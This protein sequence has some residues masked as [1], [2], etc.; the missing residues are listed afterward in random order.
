[1]HGQCGKLWTWT[2]DILY[3]VIVM[4]SFPECM[5]T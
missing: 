5:H 4:T 3:G 2:N 1:M